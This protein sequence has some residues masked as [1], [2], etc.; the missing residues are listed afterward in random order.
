MRSADSRT[1]RAISEGLAWDNHGCMPLRPLD[2]DFLPQLRRYA[3]AGFRVVGINVG[4]DAVPWAETLRMLASFRG[5]I[6]KHPK[7][8]ALLSTPGDL[9]RLQGRLGLFFDIEGGSALNE[10]LSMVELY[11][12]LGV[13]WM[14]IA[15]NKNNALGGGCQDADRGL[16]KFGR[17]VIKEMNRV[18]MTVCCSHTGYK[19]TMD[20]M[21]GAA[22]PVI[23]SHSNPLG[24]W[25]HKRNIRDEAIKACA[26]T[27][28]VVGI[29][30][31]G[32]F[33]GK[34]DTRSETVAA[35]I[36]YV[37]QLVGADH[38][39]LG[40]DYV[41][42]TAELEEYLRANP[43][44]FPPEEGYG[45]TFQQVAPEQLP[46]IVDGMFARGYTL[47]DVRK[48]IGGNFRRIARETW[49]RRGEILS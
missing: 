14:L 42:D 41:F 32:L 43:K 15:Y 6:A 27:G 44:I 31:I 28:G 8:Y 24:V 12:D 26:A 29:N 38:V 2:D 4:F 33:L 1:A 19:T 5:W 20:V 46:E 3:K 40:L 13:R 30:G 37:V 17:Q 39:G 25:R 36:D 45:G 10:Q 22:R 35:H 21:R 7:Q 23:F 49:P 11:R 18:G 16:T 48:I 47:S 34:N 9:S